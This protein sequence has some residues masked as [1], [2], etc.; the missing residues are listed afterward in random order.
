MGLRSPQT[1]ET[2]MATTKGRKRGRK[3]AE[4]IGLLVSQALRNLDE[5]ENLEESPLAGL[6]AI[7]HLATTTY[8]EALF[9]SGM[10]VRSLL[11]VAVDKVCSDLDGMAGYQ[12][13]L[14]FLRTISKGVSV[15]EFS[16]GLGLSREHIAR[17]VQPRAMR[18]LTKAFLTQT[19]GVA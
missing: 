3:S 11:L 8:S 16:R 17:T 5:L 14:E 12:R 9:P 1:E 7:R 13:E 4:E 15:A 2:L 10:A 18:L 6:A 19:L